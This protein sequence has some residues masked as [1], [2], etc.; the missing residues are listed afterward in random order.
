MEKKIDQ[1]NSTEPRKQ[2]HL[3]T[4][5]YK[6][7]SIEQLQIR[8]RVISKLILKKLLWKNKGQTFETKDTYLIP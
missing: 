7:Y 8:E 4:K 2:A 6:M 3:C 5:K 1:R